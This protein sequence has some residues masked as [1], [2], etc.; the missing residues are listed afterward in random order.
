MLAWNFLITAAWKG[1]VLEMKHVMVEDVSWAEQM[2][3][4]LAPAL[5][6]VI[7][8]SSLFLLF[9]WPERRRGCIFGVLFHIDL[10]V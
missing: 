10:F 3:L 8:R 9:F 6:L 7:Q 1:D 4:L 2:Y 5:A